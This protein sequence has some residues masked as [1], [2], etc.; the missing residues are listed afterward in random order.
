LGAALGEPHGEEGL[1]EDVGGLGLA[2]AHVGPALGD[3]ERGW[4]LVL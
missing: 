2:A 1:G 4:I 3:S